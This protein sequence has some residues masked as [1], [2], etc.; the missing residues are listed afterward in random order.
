MKSVFGF[1]HLI[2]LLS[3]LA[4]SE[5]DCTLF[6]KVVK[7]EH[8]VEVTVSNDIPP[9]DYGDISY[10]EKLKLSIVESTSGQSL[11]NVNS[12]AWVVFKKYA[13]YIPEN[14]FPQYIKDSGNISLSYP[15]TSII[16]PFHYFF[17]SPLLHSIPF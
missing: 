4:Y 10:S 2:I 1:I 12:I 8:K 6:E 16:F 11:R 13:F 9:R 15:K 5:L 7:A 3:T 14:R 17:W